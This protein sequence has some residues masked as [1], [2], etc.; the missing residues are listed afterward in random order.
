MNLLSYGTNPPPAPTSGIP[1]AALNFSSINQWKTYGRLFQT[2]YLPINSNPPPTTYFASTN[3]GLTTYTYGNV[4]IAYYYPVLYEQVNDPQYSSQLNLTLTTA[5]LLPG[6][7][8]TSRILYTFQGLNDPVILELI[9][10]NT[11]T[12]NAYRTLNTFL[13]SLVNEYSCT[14]ATYNNNI[15]ISTNQLNTSKTGSNL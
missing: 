11:T 13:N 7:T 4:L 5:T 8:V 6:E 2:N 1:A 12:L 14:Y 15:S 9:N 10:Q 3:A